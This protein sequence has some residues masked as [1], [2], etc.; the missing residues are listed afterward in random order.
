[1]L[2]NLSRFKFVLIISC[3][4]LIA[5]GCAS[6]KAKPDEMGHAELLNRGL[7][8]MKKGDPSYAL[9]VL[10]AVKD[11]YPY[12]ES[13]II[14]SLK[15]GDTYFAMDEYETAYGLYDEFEKYHPKDVNIPYVKYQKAM[16]FFKQI[17]AFDRQQIHVLKARLEFEKL[18]RLYP[19]DEYTVMARRNLRK[20]LTYL[21][22]FEISTA[23]FYFNQEQY[24]AALLR[25]TYAVNN[26]PD[27][28]QYHEALEKIAYCKAK[29][30]ES[31]E[32]TEEIEQ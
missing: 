8:L 24:K 11:R 13:A 5:G 31:G 15:L 32:E 9:K 29:L 20:C 12:T 21:T 26:F 19:D 25:Y 23:N 28:G 3:L 6:K 4:V 30:A 2:K 16:C 17:K 27:I 22:Q 18:V 14:A 1:M 7:E 10:Q